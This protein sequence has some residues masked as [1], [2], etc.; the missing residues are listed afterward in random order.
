MLAPVKDQG[1][2]VRTHGSNY[3]GVL[4]LITGLVDFAG[5]VD[6][7]NDVECKGSFCIAMTS[8][9]ARLLIVLGWI[10][11][12]EF[13]NFDACYLKVVLGL[14]RGIGSE[15]QTM[16]AHFCAWD[17]AFRLARPRFWLSRM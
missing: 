15:Q 10:R 9:L 1:P 2:P 13:R 4:R 17:S 5:M 8:N 3:V 12:A 14:S 7:L 16:L 6:L 11:F